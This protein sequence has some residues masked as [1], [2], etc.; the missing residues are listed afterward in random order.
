M[1]L[2][3]SILLIILVVAALLF[4][5]HA[6]AKVFATSYLQVEIPDA[7]DCS[8]IDRVWACQEKNPTHQR[9]AVL[10]IT[11]KQAG[12][13]DYLESLRAQLKSPQSITGTQRTAVTSKLEWTKDLRI[14]EE[15][16]VEFLHLNREI[17]GF[18]TYYLATVARG[19]TVIVSFSFEKS[20]TKEMQA[21]MN[22]LRSTLKLIAKPLEPADSP[23]TPQAADRPQGL[24]ALAGDTAPSSGGPMGGRAGLSLPILLVIGAI[25][26]VGAVFYFKRK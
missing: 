21:M 4:G 24:A 26:A 23:V 17:E 2:F 6:G 5:D 13:Q 12:P 8:N 7:W 22:Q 14:G 25:L 3:E 19:L 16:W 11:A 20:K 15:P 1:R 9:S 10:V 18:Y